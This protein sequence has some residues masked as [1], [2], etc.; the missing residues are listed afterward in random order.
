MSQ[1]SK[2]FYVAT[3]RKSES[4]RKVKADSRNGVKEKTRKAR[5]QGSSLKRSYE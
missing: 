5:R 4:N 2:S 3:V 1:S